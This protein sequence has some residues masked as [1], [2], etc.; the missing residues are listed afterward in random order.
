MELGPIEL[1]DPSDLYPLVA[2]A[3]NEA[4]CDVGLSSICRNAIRMIRDKNYK[5]DR[6]IPPNETRYLSKII[7]PCSNIECLKDGSLN[8]ITT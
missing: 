4:L 3:S 1:N 8:N 7:N 2:I 6:F 5:P